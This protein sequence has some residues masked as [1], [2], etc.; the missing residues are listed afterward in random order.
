MMNLKFDV[1]IRDNADFNLKLLCKQEKDTQLTL[2]GRVGGEDGIDVTI[3][4]NKA[5]K[6]DMI[7]VVSEDCFEELKV[8]DLSYG[9]VFGSTEDYNVFCIKTRIHFKE[10]DQLFEIFLNRNELEAVF[11]AQKFLVP[12]IYQVWGE[13]EIEATSVE[14]ARKKLADPDFVDKMGLPEKPSYLDDSY[15]IDTEGEIKNVD[16]G[17]TFPISEE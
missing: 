3:Y 4:L 12:V 10:S 2:K 5:M 17:E 16:T 11:K 6:K 7:L 9:N 1:L 13:V 8:S 14:E 15:V